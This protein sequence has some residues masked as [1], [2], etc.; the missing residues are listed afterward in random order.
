M[1][2]LVKNSH[3]ISLTLTLDVFVYVRWA[4]NAIL[5]I[6]KKTV[7]RVTAMPTSHTHTLFDNVGIQKQNSS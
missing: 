6:A 2:L 1:R 4:E 3:L 5:K 7:V